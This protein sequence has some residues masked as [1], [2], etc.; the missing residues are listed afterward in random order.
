MHRSTRLHLLI[1]ASLI[2]LGLQ[3]S[4]L[5][6]RSFRVA[7]MPNGSEVSCAA[8]HENPNGG[9]PR[10]PFGEDV[11]SLVTRGGRQQFWTPDLAMKDSDM[12]GF[13]NGQE[14]GDEDGDGTSN[15]S[16]NIASPGNNGMF[17][18]MAVGDCN[19]DT[20]LN[21]MDLSCVSTI[22]DRDAVLGELNTLPGD[23]DGDGTVAFA[24]FVTL[25]IN[26]NQDAPAYTDGN[27]DLMGPVDFADFVI[28]SIN[29]GNTPAAAA[30][31]PEPSAHWLGICAVAPFLMWR[32]RRRGS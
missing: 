14:L 3:A 28:M 16:V 12:D 25:S 26:F 7:M 13:T 27:I 15:R 11:N 18:E 10:T 8:C 17:P 30:A 5:W 19:L 6:G 20:Q 32:R 23:L 2:M 4:P 21:G 31:V 24:D 1:T 22:E 9:G 29:F